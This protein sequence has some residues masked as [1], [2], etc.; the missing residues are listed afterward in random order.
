MEMWLW[1]VHEDFG[2]ALGRAGGAGQMKKQEN[3]G[4][5]SGPSPAKNLSEKLH[6]KEERQE[7]QK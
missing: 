6:T 7:E 5:R 3:L 2:G 4:T 1:S